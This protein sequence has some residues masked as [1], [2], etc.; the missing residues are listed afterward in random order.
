MATCQNPEYI[1][2]TNVDYFGFSTTFNPYLKT[3]TFI[4]SGYTEF[5]AGGEANI[6]E[7]NFE[8]VD[9][10]ENT[11]TATINPSASETQV[12]ISNLVG[13]LLYF[14]TYHIKGTL[15]EA[16]ASTYDIE[17]DVEV[18]DSNLLKSSN[19]IVGCVSAEA[20]CVTAKLTITD[21]NSYIYNKMDAEY[22]EYDNKMWLPDDPDG[23]LE[24]FN[25]TDLPYVKSLNGFY[26]GNYQISVTA[27]ATYAL[28]CASF[29][30]IT[31]K[32]NLTK[33]ID[34]TASLCELNC[35]WTESN[36]IASGGGQKA[37]QM[38][39]KIIEATPYYL[40]AVGNYLCGKNAEKA[41]AKVNDIL[42]CSCTCRQ[43]VIQPAPITIGNSNIFGDCGTTVEKDDNG[44]IH[45]HSFAYTISKGDPND[46]GYSITTT[47]IN[48]CTKRTVIAFDY[49]VFQQNILNA[50]ANNAQYILNWQTVLGIKDCP[51]DDVEIDNGSTLVTLNT[52]SSDFLTLEDTYFVKNDV[53]TGVEYD[54]S[55]TITGGTLNYVKYTDQ[56]IQQ[57]GVVTAGQN[58][59]LPCGVCGESITDLTG[60]KLVTEAFSTCGCI[61]KKECD[62]STPQVDY[63]ERYVSAYRFNPQIDDAPTTTYS[64]IIDGQ[65]YTM[66]KLYFA[67]TDNTI[68]YSAV[69]VIIFKTDNVGTTTL[70]ETRTIIGAN[71]GAFT[72]TINNTWGNFV[73]FDRPSSINL[74][75]SE[76]VNGE[77]V[78]YFVTFGGYVCR[79]VRER[80]TECDERA[81]WKVY[82][83]EDSGN[84]LYGMKKWQIDANGNQS[85]LIVNNTTSKLYAVTY[86]GTGTKNS[87]ANW[88]IT[89]ID[90]SVSGS[91]GNFNVEMSNNYI[92][93]LGAGLIKLVEYIGTSSLSDIQNPAKYNEYTLCG[94]ASP[95]ATS[96]IDDTGLKA[97]L[98]QP[99]WM[100]KIIVGGEDRYYFG[101]ADADF[102]N[103][104]IK[105][106]Y[107][108]YMTLRGT[109][110]TGGSDWDFK[111]EI[112]V[113]NDTIL[114][115]GAWVEDVSTTANGAS[116]GMTYVEDL[117]WV[118]M[119]IHGVK[120]F[121]FTNKT[122]EI[123]SGQEVA[124]GNLVIDNFMD[125]QFAYTLGNC[126]GGGSGSGE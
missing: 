94:N 75:M 114:G 62:L 6:S 97:T 15:V 55:T 51:C 86:N 22:V 30:E 31:Y 64:E 58:I 99:S 48:E 12:T 78:L 46:L 1:N 116:Q 59:T 10:Q 67:D 120:V 96:Y 69:R 9:P 81:N 21:Q 14:G 101:N 93:T 38:Q 65:L 60:Y 79:A 83:L 52:Q 36:Q 95:T 18:C 100:Q 61:E 8:V 105:S 13:G 82:V 111:T 73:V 27:V 122:V 7:I 47:Q 89:D 35:C 49:N 117:G 90:I 109:A 3:V 124:N 16:N 125:T 32:G 2:T 24:E 43:Y 53:I 123:F 85:F 80:G 106:S 44:D 33:T 34:C 107:I 5:K 29:L 26:T 20:N 42:G 76:I 39:D 126:E 4:I 45:I 104:Y 41:I 98:W 108:R 113:D 72:A 68:N 87:S 88:T 23:S 66:T 50:I 54:D 91:N 37:G 112:V 121:D 84:S 71:T 92:F 115:D 17:F 57:S 102:T 77:P 40:E 70:H 63:S 25:F 110:P 119:F 103:N 74:D 11:Y 56:I 19:Y 28:D 118:S